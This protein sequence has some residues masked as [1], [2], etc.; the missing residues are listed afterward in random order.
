M[1]RNHPS[2]LRRACAPLLLLA[3]ALPGA[4]RA[5]AEALAFV[6]GKGHGAVTMA[7]GTTEVDKQILF[8]GTEVSPG[9]ISSRLAILAVDYGLTDKLAVSFSIPF[10]EKK[11]EGARPHNPRI[12]LDPEDRQSPFIDDG[13]YHGGWQDFGLKLRYNLTDYPWSVTPYVALNVPSHDYV[14]FAH[15]AIGTRQDSVQ[16]GVDLGRRFEPPFQDFYLQVGYGYTFVEEVRGVNVDFS[17]VTF[18]FGYLVTP[19]LVA[20]VVGAWRYSHGGSKACLC[21]VSRVD[22]AY[23]HHDQTQRNDHLNVGVGLDYLI[24]D[25]WNVTATYGRTVWGENTTKIQPA[26]SLGVTRSF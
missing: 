21:P 23:F 18:D 19:G 8:D 13:N 20:R 12:L 7:V 24:S 15:S 2:W 11:Y 3:L 22:D 9:E 4:A 5:Q 25:N 10:V 26:L 16:L 14:F 17:Q 1:K 6:P